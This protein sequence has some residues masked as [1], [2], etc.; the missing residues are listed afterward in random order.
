[1]ILLD[2]IKDFIDS[3]DRKIVVFVHHI[4]VAETL[5][6]L[7]QNEGIKALSTVKDRSRAST[8]YN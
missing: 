4:D 5:V 8:R 6:S 1:M 2:F 3:T 7:L